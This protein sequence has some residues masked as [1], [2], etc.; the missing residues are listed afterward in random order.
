MAGRRHTEVGA[1]VELKVEGNGRGAKSG[2]ELFSE[3]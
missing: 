2:L 1:G 3:R